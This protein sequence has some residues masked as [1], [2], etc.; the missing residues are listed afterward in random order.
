MGETVLQPCP[1]SP[2]CVCSFENPKDSTHYIKPAKYESSPLEKIK[3]LLEKD[4]SYKLV[5][6]KN[7]Y[8]KYEFTSSLFKF[9]DDIEFLYLSTEKLLHMRSA[10]RVGYS[11]LGANRKRINEIVAKLK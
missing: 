9:V 10:S 1:S 7:N 6:E 4:K 8:L 2:N 11:D 5:S 3:S